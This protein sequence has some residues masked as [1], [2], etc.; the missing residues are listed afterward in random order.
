LLKSE[1]R[2]VRDPEPQRGPAPASA[3]SLQPDETISL[4]RP[5]LSVQRTRTTRTTLQVAAAAMVAGLLTGVILTYR[6]DTPA[7]LRF[8]APRLSSAAPAQVGARHETR[9]PDTS[10]AQTPTVLRTVPSPA[11]GA[12]I[13]SRKAEPVA[14]MPRHQDSAGQAA[15]IF[16]LADLASQTTI[17]S[18][19]QPASLDLPLRSR[20]LRAILAIPE[21]PDGWNFPSILVGDLNQNDQ[22][23]GAV[24]QAVG[25][26]AKKTGVVFAKVGASMRRVF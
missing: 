20:E 10:T 14:E 13:P 23:T 16:Q 4:A 26:A 22:D 6:F 15:E 1:T 19:P 18:S 11:T 17:P 24:R 12:A 2:G 7:G 25:Q 21:V 3:P 9:H 5:V 8:S